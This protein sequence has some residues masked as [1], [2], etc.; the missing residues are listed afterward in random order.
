M[1]KYLI[2]LGLIIAVCNDVWA[3]QIESYD[4]CGDGSCYS[5][6]NLLCASDCVCGGETGGDIEFGEEMVAC[7]SGSSQCPGAV[8][9]LTCTKSECN[10]LDSIGEVSLAGWVKKTDATFT[11]QCSDDGATYSCKCNKSSAYVCGDGYWGTC[12][13]AN[14]STTC[15]CTA[16]PDNS[17][18]VAGENESLMCATGYYP[19]SKQ[20][21]LAFPVTWTYSCNACPDNATC[22]DNNVTC[23]DGYYRKVNTDS[24]TREVI[25]SCIVCPDNATCSDNNITCD[26]GYYHLSN[27]AGES[28]VCPDN[29]TCTIDT[30]TCAKNYYR[31]GSVL[32]GGFS[33]EPCPDN[34]NT[35][36]VGAT[37]ITQC[38]IGIDVELDDG[39]GNLF[40]YDTPCYYTN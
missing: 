38:F 29:A 9:D 14:D 10:C 35:D 5:L 18:C 31:T 26:D 37:S 13:D 1:K 33:C 4:C 39:N 22:S 15:S 20:N 23:D 36:A 40:Y 16:C 12:T 30:V 28:C 8:A 25:Y 2:L 32:R 27:F 6:N 24:S 34:G 21:S 11:I 17:S 3:A 19:V 7:P